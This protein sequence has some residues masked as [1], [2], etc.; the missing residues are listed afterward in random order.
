MH[1]RNVV[2]V[3]A[4]RCTLDTMVSTFGFTFDPRYAPVL[5]LGGIT[6]ATATLRVDD[7]QLT[8]RFGRF[9]LVT[10]R[11]NVTEASITGP[12][13]PYRAIGLRMSLSDRG[14]TFG[15]SVERMVCMQFAKPVRI[16]PFDIASHP[17]LSVSVDRPQELVT[18][19]R[20]GS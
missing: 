14:L 1:Q 15:T 19:L 17:G 2:V 11:S 9:T 18:L 6:P 13:K 12:H 10:P 5:R 4:S 7:E 8:A 16:R 20:G 3:A